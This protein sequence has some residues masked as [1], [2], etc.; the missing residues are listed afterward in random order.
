[1]RSV[2]ICQFLLVYRCCHIDEYDV[3]MLLFLI[4]ALLAKE[5]TMAKTEG[6]IIIIYCK[7]LFMRRRKMVA[8][9]CEAAI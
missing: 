1:M 4:S 9:K 6:F 8:A 2:A 5:R 3:F 7:R